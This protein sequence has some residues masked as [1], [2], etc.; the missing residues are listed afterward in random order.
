MK[1]ANTEFYF[2][3]NKNI[4]EDEITL[5]ENEA[6]HAIKVMRKNVG[7]KLYVTDGK[8][9]VYETKILFVYQ[10]DVRLKIV[11]REFIKEKFPNINFYIPTLKSP[12]RLEFALEKLV[13][14]GFT[15]FIFFVAE[16]SYKKNIKF[17][18]LGKIALAAM[19]QSLQAHLPKLILLEKLKIQNNETTIIFEQLAEE[20]FNGFVSSS[21]SKNYNLVFGPEGGL[22]DKEINSIENRKLLNL[23]ENRLRA[24]TAMIAAGSVISIKSC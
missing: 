23:T 2:S 1:Y 21:L 18:R 4:S 6:K 19:K 15:N 13:E 9:N 17:E 14:L 7:E 3:P 12:D 8:G 24:E 16:K 22:T 20:N 5:S 11:N 10:N